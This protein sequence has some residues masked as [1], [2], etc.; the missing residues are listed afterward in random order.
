VAYTKSTLS[1]RQKRRPVFNPRILIIILVIV[2]FFLCLIGSGRLNSFGCGGDTSALQNYMTQTKKISDRSNKVGTDFADL[3]TNIKSLARKDLDKKLTDM[4]KESRTILADAKKVEVPTKM[5]DANSYLLISLELR[6]SALESYKPAI[7]NALGDNDLEVSA[8]QVSLALKDMAFSD[9]AF[10]MFKDKAAKV[11]KDNN[12]TFI[13]PPTS[14]FLAGDAEYEFANVLEFLKGIKET[15]V[16]LTEKHGI[17]IVE[18]VMEPAATSDKDGVFVLPFAAEVAVTVTVENQG[19]QLEVNVPVV[20]TLKSETQPKPQ[21]KK[22]SITS[23]PAGQKKTIK[24]TGLK[25]TSGDIVNMLTI[26]AGPVPNEK[27]LDNNMSELKFT[28]ERK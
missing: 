7:F 15:A 27:F 19:N 12:T 26:Q 6:A 3:R 17:A 16:D 13:S 25:A 14:V 18:V 20:A 21:S 1:Y 8:K 11:L 24:I 28:M 2:F 23:L 5:V 22:V 9:R 10:A 4:A